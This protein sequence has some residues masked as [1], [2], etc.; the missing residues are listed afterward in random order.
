M[1]SNWRITTIET[2]TCRLDIAFG[3]QTLITLWALMALSGCLDRQTNL[4]RVQIDCV[5]ALSTLSE[6]QRRRLVWVGPK[7]DCLLACAQPWHVV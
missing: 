1:R 7:I 5:Q 6:L 3:Q 2:F 4:P